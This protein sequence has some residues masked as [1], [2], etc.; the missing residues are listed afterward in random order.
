MTPEA[1]QYAERIREAFFGGNDRAIA[2]IYRELSEN[3][4]LLFSVWGTFPATM[5]AQLKEILGR[6]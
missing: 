6:E 2:E 5:R 3:Q 4:E 1:R